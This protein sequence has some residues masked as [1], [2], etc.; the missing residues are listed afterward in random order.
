MKRAPGED[1]EEYRQRRKEGNV[2]KKT[3]GRFGRWVH[4]SGT[5]QKLPGGAMSKG[6]TYRKVHIAPGPKRTLIAAAVGKRHKGESVE[7]FK[8]RRGFL[9]HGAGEKQIL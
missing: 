4:Q 2:I 7:H 3:I 6:V 1:F 5:Y 8:A 9:M